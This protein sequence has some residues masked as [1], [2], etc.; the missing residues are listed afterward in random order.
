MKCKR[1]YQKMAGTI[2][3]AGVVFGLMIPAV[4]KQQDEP[5]SKEPFDV[6]DFH[7]TFDPIAVAPG[8]D[9]AAISG[10]NKVYSQLFMGGTG[11]TVTALDPEP[12]DSKPSGMSDAELAE[13]LL[14]PLGYLWILYLQ[15]DITYLDGDLNEMAGTGEKIMHTTK[16]IPVFPM[17]LTEEWSLI[18]RPV[19]QYH[20]VNAP[21][22]YTIVSGT[23]DPEEEPV[24][25]PRFSREDGLGDTV[26]LANISNQTKPPFI[27]GF[28]PTFMF[29]TASDDRLGSEKW[30]VGPSGLMAHISEKW[31]F[32]VIGQHWWSFAGDDD[33]DSVNVTD[34]QPVVR[35]RITP[36]TNVGCAPNI[37]YNWSEDQLTLP[38]G[39]G[40][41]T[42]IKIG[43]IPI[44]L[45][46]ESYYYLEQDDMFGPEWGLR[47]G[48][49]T[50]IPSPEWSRNPLL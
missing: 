36:E 5:A 22:R 14:N 18:L 47:F 44:S 9:A 20:S 26:L 28:G 32:G 38:V 24:I 50:V 13:M 3:L 23:P 46:F 29:P 21:F 8:Y 41:A 40:M 19:I 2:I 11:T 16:F 12:M 7:V 37:Q 48:I 10:F 45:G 39:L 49:S 27:Y 35:Y 4:A 34:V 31:V 30:A 25:I 17:K 33:R 42:L 15:H 1:W 6:N 43:E